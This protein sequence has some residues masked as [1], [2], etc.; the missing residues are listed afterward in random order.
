[1]NKQIKKKWVDALRSGKYKQ[2]KE[3]L[4]DETG[5]CCLGVLCVVYAEEKKINIED[6]PGFDDEDQGLPNKVVTWAKLDSSNPLVTI[7]INKVERIKFLTELNDDDG[8]SFKYIAN[9]IERNL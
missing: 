7:A 3:F 8:K 2:T 6:I 5:Y 1:M 9:V 4:K